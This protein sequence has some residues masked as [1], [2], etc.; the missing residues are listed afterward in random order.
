[1]TLTVAMETSGESQPV[2]MEREGCRLQDCRLALGPSSDEASNLDGNLYLCVSHT[3]SLKPG[4]GKMRAQAPTLAAACFYP[5]GP[6]A[7]CM[8]STL[9]LPARGRAEELWWGP[10]CPQ[11]L[12]CLPSGLFRQGLPTQD[13]RRDLRDG[14]RWCLGGLSDQT[15][16]SA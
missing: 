8:L 10:L 7:V 13:P 15:A 1:M 11:S 9:A 4:L 16:A 2:P 6:T 12:T 5:S 3:P 14:G